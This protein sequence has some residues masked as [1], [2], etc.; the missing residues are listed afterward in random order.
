MTVQQIVEKLGGGLRNGAT[1]KSVIIGGP[2]AGVIPPHLLDTPFGFEEMHA[3]GASVGHGG[4]VAFD[5]H[6]SIPELV[7]HVFSFGAYDHAEM[8]AVPGRSAHI[9]KLFGDIVKSDAVPV[10]N[11]S[12]FEQLV[13]ALKWTNWRTAASSASSPIGL[14]LLSK[15]PRIMLCV[16]IN[17]K[18]HEFP[19]GLTILAAL[20]EVGIE[21][22]TVCHDD[23]LNPPARAGSARSR[24][25][26]GRVGTPP[27]ATHRWQTACRSG[28][29]FFAGCRRCAANVVAIAGCRILPPKPS[30][31]F[32]RNNF[33]GISRNIVSRHWEK[34]DPSRLIHRI[35][36]SM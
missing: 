24:S 31:N 35:R 20:R 12:E 1:L 17:D 4:I 6:T 14:A 21:V 18:A 9:E 34:S 11:F 8:H 28:L 26:A 23:R 7:H 19:D 30:A 25:Q 13:R 3:I 10:T 15:R 27:P 2:L 5:E 16:T 29:P 33:T 36:T 22:P 32:P